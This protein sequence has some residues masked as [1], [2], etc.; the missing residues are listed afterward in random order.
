MTIIEVI[1][2]Y[3]KTF[4]LV[5]SFVVTFIT[6]LLQ[7]KFTNQSHLKNLK[8]R[9]KEIQKEMRGNKDTKK[10]GQLQMESLKIS[11]EMMKHSFSLKHMMTTM[12]PLLI[13]FFYLRK[14]MTPILSS[15]LWWYIGFSVV[16]SIIIRKKLDVA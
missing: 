15:W 11:G 1:T 14:L 5:V 6:T 3:P 4:L 12:F 8:E 16:S 9:Q 10:I 13:L 2:A 7:K